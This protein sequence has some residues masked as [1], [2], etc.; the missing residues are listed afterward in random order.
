MHDANAVGA[1][2]YPHIYKGTRYEVMMETD[3]PV[4]KGKS[5]VDERN[6]PQLATNAEILLEINYDRMME[7]LVEDLKVLE[8]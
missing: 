3:S 6:Y 5:W 1:L 7:S 4:F 8:K 2:A